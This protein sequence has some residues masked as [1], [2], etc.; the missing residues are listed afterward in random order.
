MIQQQ[1]PL[2]TITLEWTSMPAVL[3]TQLSAYPALL[4]P[5]DV[6]E[7][8]IRWLKKQ[9]VCAACFSR[10][11]DASDTH[12]PVQQGAYVLVRL[13]TG[14]EIPLTNAKLRIGAKAA[15]CDYVIRD[16]A[17]ISRHHADLIVSGG[18]CYVADA[19]STNGTWVNGEAVP[20]G[21]QVRLQSGDLLCLDRER[22]QI[23][24]VQIA[25]EI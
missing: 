18:L 6:P 20:P 14:E 5:K 1:V 24:S 7:R 3:E 2:L 19:G 10:R 25:K 23:R 13:R 8:L 11:P 17:G 12:V 16:H 9:P 21:V 4:Y 22:F 15:L